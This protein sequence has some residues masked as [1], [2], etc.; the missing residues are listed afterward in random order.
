MSQDDAIWHVEFEK[1]KRGPLTRRQMLSGLRDGTFGGDTPIW[2]PGFDSWV[3]LREVREFWEPPRPEVKPAPPS[4]P[5][6]KPAV[7]PPPMPNQAAT[8]TKQSDE[9][10]SLWG[11]AIAGLVVS[12]VSLFTRAFTTEGY[13][14]AS[15]GYS[16]NGELIANFIGELL[17]ISLLFVLIA[18]IR[19]AVKHRSLRPSSAS[20]GR[21]A[22]IFF[23]IL[24][25]I[26]IS[27]RIFGILY[28][29]SDEIITGDARA[30]MVNN[31]LKGCFPTQRAAAVNTSATD[32]QIESYCNCIANALV[33]TLTYKQLGANNLMDN[34]K[35]HVPTA[36]QSCKG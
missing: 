14:L 9:K 18:A 20:A 19:N 33:S 5:E 36:A 12:S 28:F 21:R 1:L 3:P 7:Q 13:M 29:S 34:L 35:Q 30:G 6:V 4:R 26:G 24:I 8:A 27:L 32:T 2:R 10:W 25:A 15:T 16:P 17:S 31:F 23:G 22:A 11:A